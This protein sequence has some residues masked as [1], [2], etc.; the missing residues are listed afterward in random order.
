MKKKSLVMAVVATL[1][2]SMAGCGGSEKSYEKD[3]DAFEDAFDLEWY[4]VEDLDDVKDLEKDL[5]KI[6][7]VTKEGKQYKKCLEKRLEILREEVKLSEKYDVED[8]LEDFCDAA[9]DAGVDE[10]DIDEVLGMYN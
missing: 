8:I 10:D 9:D 6:K 2:L 7:F 3:L 4:D 1:V 5:K